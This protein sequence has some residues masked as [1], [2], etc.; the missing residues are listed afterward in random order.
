YEHPCQYCLGE[1]LHGLVLLSTPTVFPCHASAWC[2][3]YA[4]L[5]LML[6]WVLPNLHAPPF[7][8]NVLSPVPHPC[9]TS[10]GPRLPSRFDVGRPMKRG[11]AHAIEETYNYYIKGL[12]QACR[13]EQPPAPQKNFF[14][15]NSKQNS[16]LG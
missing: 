11:H 5:M 13:R 6:L 15:A 1:T 14:C 16:M 7:L 2:E 8:R 12:L 3:G 4:Q 9:R 10:E